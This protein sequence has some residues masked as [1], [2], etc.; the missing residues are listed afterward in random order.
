MYKIYDPETNPPE[1]DN[2]FG[3]NLLQFQLFKEK[4]KLEIEK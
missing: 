4:N 2:I 3:N 1:K